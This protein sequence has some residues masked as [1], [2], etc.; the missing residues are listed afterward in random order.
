MV[1]YLATRL[2]GM[3]TFPAGWVSH[4]KYKYVVV[5]KL[6]ENDNLY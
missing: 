6:V 5:G 1:G 2:D 3:L 4:F